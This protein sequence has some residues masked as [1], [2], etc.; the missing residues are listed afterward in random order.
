MV[1]TNFDVSVMLMSCS[2]ASTLR[3]NGDF[4]ADDRQTK[5]IALPLTHACEII[6]IQMQIL[7][8]ITIQAL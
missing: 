7:P 6:S 4:S 3:N 5:A 2:D 8:V 1:F